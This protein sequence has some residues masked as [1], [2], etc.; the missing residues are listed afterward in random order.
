MKEISFRPEAEADIDA[1]WDYTFQTWGRSQANRY[2]EDIRAAI[3]A[4]ADQTRP[5]RP[6]DGVRQGYRRTLIGTHVVF[7]RDGDGTVDIVRVLHQRMDF[8]GKV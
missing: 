8:E 3:N 6:A 4:V 2:A 1:I 7:F 5:S